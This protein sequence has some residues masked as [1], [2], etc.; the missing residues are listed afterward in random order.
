[1][2]W[3]KAIERNCAA[4]MGIVSALF[5]LLMAGRLGVG[6]VVPR[7]VWRAVLLVLR[8]AEAALRRLV[9]L[10][11]RNLKTRHTALAAACGIGPHGAR[12]GLCPV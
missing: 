11:A 12:P 1:M 5:A 6:L 3:D 4:L 9:V 10:A 7:P 8:P 2:D